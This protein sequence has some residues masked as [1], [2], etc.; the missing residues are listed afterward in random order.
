MHQ[1]PSTCP[2][3]GVSPT[4]PASRPTG[5][6]ITGH[7][8]HLARIQPCALCGLMVRY[9]VEVSATKDNPMLFRD[10]PPPP[11][12]QVGALCAYDMI[13]AKAPKGMKHDVPP[14]SPDYPR[15]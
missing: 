9:G 10:A 3:P 1:T 14:S 15:G 5:W 6:A 12:V 2:A 8:D 7:K 4:A 13:G 11:P